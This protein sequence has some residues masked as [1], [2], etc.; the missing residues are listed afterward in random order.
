M[1][2]ALLRIPREEAVPFKEDEI[3]HDTD[4]LKTMHLES[5]SVKMEPKGVQGMKGTCHLTHL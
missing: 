1:Y 4:I 2:T 5:V 3:V